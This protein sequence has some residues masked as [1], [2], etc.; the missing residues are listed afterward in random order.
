MRRGGAGPQK[1]EMRD[2]G[3]KQKIDREKKEGDGG[4][5]DR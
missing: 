3:S 5:S 2:R 4:W 1:N